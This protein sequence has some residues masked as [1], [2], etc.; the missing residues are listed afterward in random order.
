VLNLYLAQVVIRQRLLED[1]KDR[2]ISTDVGIIRGDSS[3]AELEC[4]V[5][6]QQATWDYGSETYDE[7]NPTE[8][9]RSYRLSV[10]IG[11]HIFKLK[12]FI[13]GKHES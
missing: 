4:D 11:V 7:N 3:G 2:D 6:A 5:S 10:V 13:L 12:P 9:D 8:G 1:V